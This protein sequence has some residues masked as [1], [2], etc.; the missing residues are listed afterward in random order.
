MSRAGL[1][2]KIELNQLAAL[3][4]AK[5]VQIEIERGGTCER[6]FPDWEG[7]GASQACAAEISGPDDSS[8]AL[9]GALGQSRKTVR[10]TPEFCFDFAP[11]FCPAAGNVA[12]S[13]PMV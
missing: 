11:D 4:I 7:G 8:Q 1:I 10:K 6:Y 12:V 13:K 3:A 2:S 5:N 9:W